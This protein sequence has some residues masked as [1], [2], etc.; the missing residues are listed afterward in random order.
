MP[1]GTVLDGRSE[2]ISEGGMLA[3]V[4]ERCDGTA[5][6]QVRFALP[7]SGRV[8]TAAAHSRWVRDARAGAAAGLEFDPLPEEVRAAIRSYVVLMRGE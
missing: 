5:A 1:D 7:V 6:V 4:P 3:V 8:V 2:D